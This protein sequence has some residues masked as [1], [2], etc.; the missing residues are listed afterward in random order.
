MPLM[1]CEN[2]Y[3]FRNLLPDTDL[4]FKKKKKK[5]TEIGSPLSCILTRS[6]ERKRSSLSKEN[7]TPQH[8]L[9]AEE[10]QRR[11]RRPCPRGASRGMPPTRGGLSRSRRWPHTGE[12]GEHQR[13]THPCG[14]V[15]GEKREAGVPRLPDFLIRIHVSQPRRPRSARPRDS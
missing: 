1:T 7:E 15:R 13:S 4:K 9:P 11:N 5:L 3:A 6:C 12:C 8:P 10:N 14:E 2:P